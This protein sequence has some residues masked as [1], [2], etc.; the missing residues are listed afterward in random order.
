VSTDNKTG[1]IR[2]VYAAGTPSE[3]II[4]QRPLPKEKDAAPSQTKSIALREA[5]IPKSDTVNRVLVIIQNQEVL[6]EGRKTQEELLEMAK[7]LK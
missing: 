5:D 6:L 4:T 7:T 2:Q 1:V 3:L